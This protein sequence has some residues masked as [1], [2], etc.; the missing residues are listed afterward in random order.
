MRLQDIPQFTRDGSCRINQP[1]DSLESW[2]QQDHCGVVADLDPDFQR[3]HVWSKEQQVRFVEFCL[4]GGKGSNTIRFNCV[5][6][7]DDFRGPFELVDGKQRLEAVR[8]FMRDELPAIGLTR[9]QYEGK[10]PFARYDFIVR[11][12]DLPT[13]REV[14]QWYLD[15][16][17]GG[18]VHTSEEVDKV[19]AL[20]NK[21]GGP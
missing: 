17:T 3:A 14:L 8:K 7:M 2:L 21:E 4:R 5:G 18:V 13:R 11:I 20:L 15:I 1:W 10:F 16:N 19:K 9:S 6:W 12:N